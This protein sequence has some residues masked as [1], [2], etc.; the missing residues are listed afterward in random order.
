[1]QFR[2]AIL[3]CGTVGGGVARILLDQQVALHERA[4]REVELVRI[5]DL[6]PKQSAERHGIPRALYAGKGDELSPEQADAEVLGVLE[7]PDI[8]LVVETIGGSGPSILGTTRGVLEQGKHL[9]TA[10]KALLAKH[11]EELHAA[12]R[13]HGKGLGFEAAVCAA[14]PII[15]SLE[16]GL[17]G[18]EILSISGIFNGTSNYIL[19]K[20]D[21]EG[22][23]FGDALRD[24]QAKG[25]AEADPTLDING[26]DAGH[27]LTIVLRLAFGLE[28]AFED[29]PRQGIDTVTAGE[30]AFAEEMQGVIKLICHAQR[31]GD[32]VYAAVRPMIVKRTNLLSKIDGATNAVRV[33]GRYAGENMMIGQ[34]AGSLETG[35]A[36]VSDI[37]FLARYG[38]H[39]RPAPPKSE[40]RLRPLGD[41]KLPYHIVFETAD[42]PGITGIVATAIGHQDINID[43]VSHNRHENDNAEFAIATM[44]C[45]RAQVDAAVLDIQ[46]NHPGSL[47]GEPRVLPI[48]I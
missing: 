48:L 34:G 22:Q 24:A 46:N 17:T 37:V 3:G 16:D 18:E 35:S 14:I 44:P 21:T 4:G 36:I 11:G 2:V 42:V 1:M 39:P 43:S 47:L 13:E 30:V 28:V 19:S 32:F 40:L 26:G 9:V 29:V 15:R 6:F 27:K 5:V 12:A 7:D 20:M 10:N 38:D 25:Y 33:I 23:S 8:D 41:L 31:E 45:T